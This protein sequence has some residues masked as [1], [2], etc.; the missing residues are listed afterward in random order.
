MRE[1]SGIRRARLGLLSAVLGAF[2]L[3]TMASPATS[4]AA[5]KITK[6]LGVV[7]D[8]DLI[9]WGS[10]ARGAWAPDYPCFA[11]AE[12][13]ERASLGRLSRRTGTRARDGP[14]WLPNCRSGPTGCRL[15]AIWAWHVSSVAKW[16]LDRRSR[17]LSGMERPGPN[18]TSPISRPD[19]VSL[20]QRHHPCSTRLS[21]CRVFRIERRAKTCAVGR[22]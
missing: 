22:L 9:L 6:I 18:A 11:A 16:N 14:R 13:P 15:T 20:P 19:R 1:G 3:A 7:T 4:S 5:I 17:T 12:A 2:V 21:L 10:S 8:T